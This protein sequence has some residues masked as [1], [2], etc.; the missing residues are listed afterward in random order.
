[1]RDDGVQG[2]P[3]TWLSNTLVATSGAPP[4]KVTG[5]H[6]KKREKNGVIQF[7]GAGQYEGAIREGESRYAWQRALEN[8]E[9]EDMQCLKQTYSVIQNLDGGCRLRFGYTPVDEENTEG[10]QVSLGS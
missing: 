2:E 10:V 7:R 6:L 9:V 8:G 3:R 4:P 5:V 1:M